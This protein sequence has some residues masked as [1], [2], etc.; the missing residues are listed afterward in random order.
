M[1]TTKKNETKKTPATPVK[2]AGITGEGEEITLFDGTKAKKDGKNVFVLREDGYHIAS[3]TEM[4]KEGQFIMQ[5][6]KKDGGYDSFALKFRKTNDGCLILHTKTAAGIESGTTT[7]KF[8]ANKAEVKEQEVVA[9]GRGEI[10]T[11]CVIFHL[12][13][14]SLAEQLGMA[15]M[16]FPVRVELD[17]QSKVW[18]CICALKMEVLG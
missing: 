15:G 5:M 3:A 8:G 12:A 2:K 6:G 4:V 14:D 7:V 17:H 10:H 18:S 11:A 1:A 9:I 13:C 16:F